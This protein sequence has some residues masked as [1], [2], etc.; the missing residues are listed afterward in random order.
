MVAPFCIQTA[1]SGDGCQ[2]SLLQCTEKRNHT[3]RIFYQRNLLINQSF[4]ASYGNIPW[5]ILFWVSGDFYAS[6]MHDAEITKS[7]AVRVLE[8]YNIIDWKTIH[9]F[10]YSST[11]EQSNKKSGARLK[12]VGL[13]SSRVWDSYAMLKNL[14]VLEFF[15][16]D[17]PLDLNLELYSHVTMPI[18][19]CC[20]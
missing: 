8:G 12:N 6:G 10:V 2:N 9:I 7:L 5:I 14:T 17:P 18:W 15:R 20:F 4:F 1:N 13:H 11:C 16:G 19:L 3:N